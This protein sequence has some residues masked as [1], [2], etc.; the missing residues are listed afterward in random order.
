MEE[1][2]PGIVAGIEKATAPFTKPASAPALSAAEQAEANALAQK[3]V[4]A[5][6]RKRSGG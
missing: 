1:R 4:D 2:F 6:R 3:I 5:W